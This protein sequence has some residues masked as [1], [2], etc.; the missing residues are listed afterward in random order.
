MDTAT[1]NALI[2]QLP[3]PHLLQTGQWARAK[4]PFGWTAHYKT[5]EQDGKLV[6][7]AQILQRSVRLP[8]IGKELCMLYV[9]KGPL[10]ADWN[11]AA[12][13]ARVLAGLRETAKELGAF[14]IKIDPD[15]AYGYG[16]PGAE[17]ERVVPAA[18]DFVAELKSAGW[19]YSNEQVQMPNTMLI[20]IDKS[21]EDILAAMKQKGRYNLR[22]SQK[23]GVTV[24]RGTPAD[25]ATFYKMYAETSVRD[26]FVI[27][28]EEYYRAVW[29][30]FYNAGLL[31]PLLAEVEGEVVAGLM[32]FIYGE[33][34]WYIY[35]MSRALHRETMPNYLLQWEAIRASREA[36]CK[37]YDLWGAPDEFN[38]ADAM[39]GVYRFKLSL[40]AYE[41]RHIGAWDLPMQP[42]VYSMYTQVL[43]RLIAA[44]RW[45]GRRQTQAQVRSEQ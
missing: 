1:W 5:W 35:G 38:E 20:D 13:R 40:G 32:L 43:P 14:F 23:K 2:S 16:L 7:A 37:V 9:P 19:R 4:E 24:R 28:S 29:D 11:D 36:G 31:V 22:L 12:L 25:F 30:K 39:W 3:R 15:L 26:G 10:L 45:R 33:Q 8:L 17:D 42:A 34:S 21:E 44:M 18:A 41:A 6:A 27:R